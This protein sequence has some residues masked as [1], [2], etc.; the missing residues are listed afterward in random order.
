MQ[1]TL[2]HSVA[3]NVQEIIKKQ[4]EFAQYSTISEYGIMSEDIVS[5]IKGRKPWVKNDPGYWLRSGLGLLLCLDYSNVV[6]I[7]KNRSEF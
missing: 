4:C 5:E 6:L 7:D 1:V 3:D 2:L